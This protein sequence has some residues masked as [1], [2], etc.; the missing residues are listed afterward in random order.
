MKNIWIYK[1]ALFINL[2]GIKDYKNFYEEQ[3]A[4]GISKVLDVF[5]NFNDVTKREILIDTKMQYE[6]NL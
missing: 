6:S 4:F 2:M 5:S 1:Q 3:D